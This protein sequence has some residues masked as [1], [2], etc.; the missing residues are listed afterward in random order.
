MKFLSEAQIKTLTTLA[1]GGRPRFVPPITRRW[2]RER[3]WVT[4]EKHAKGG[5]VLTITDAGREALELA[6]NDRKARGLG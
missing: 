5:H 4:V 2:L 6:V 3:G 1:A